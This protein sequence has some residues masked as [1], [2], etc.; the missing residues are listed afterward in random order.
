MGKNDFYSFD[1]NT[2]VMELRSGKGLCW[3]ATGK[4]KEEAF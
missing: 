1:I 4:V 2:S 3:A